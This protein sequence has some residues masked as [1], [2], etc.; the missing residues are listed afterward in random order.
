MLD[1]V[2]FFAGTQRS[3][4]PTVHL[5]HWVGLRFVSSLRIVAHLLTRPTGFYTLFA[6]LYLVCFGIESPPGPFLVASGLADA[7]FIAGCFVTTLSAKRVLWAAAAI[8]RARSGDFSRWRR[9]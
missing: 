7:A 4:L 1:L 3:S 5:V 6:A 2:Y 8:A 9:G